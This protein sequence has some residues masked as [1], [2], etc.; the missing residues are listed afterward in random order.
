MSNP[1]SDTAQF[2]QTRR[3]E[4]DPVANYRFSDGDS[5]VI[6]SAVF[7]G[8]G[9]SLDDASRRRHGLPFSTWDRVLARLRGDD[10]D[11]D[12]G[13]EDRLLHADRAYY[14][15]NGI[16]EGDTRDLLRAWK[17]RIDPRRHFHPFDTASPSSSDSVG[18]VDLPR[19]RRG[20]VPTD[21]YARAA[22]AAQQEDDAL[23]PLDPL[24]RMHA[25][26]R[27]QRQLPTTRRDDQEADETNYFMHPFASDDED[28]RENEHEIEEN[29]QLGEHHASSSAPPLLAAPPIPAPPTP[30]VLKPEGRRQAR[31][32][33]LP[34]ATNAPFPTSESQW[35]LP[36]PDS[37]TNDTATASPTLVKTPWERTMDRIKMISSIQ[38]AR[39]S[40]Q[41]DTTTTT[42]ANAA[43]KLLVPYFPPAFDP[44]FIALSR[45]EHG[46]RLPPILLPLLNASV[47]DSEF[48]EGQNQW[49]F[50]IELQYGDIKWV[51]YRTIADFV[52]L[53]YTL[54]F[55]S[56]LLA[57]VPA[58]PPFPNQLQ[59]LYDSCITT[60][61]W[62][63]KDDDVDADSQDTLAVDENAAAARIDASPDGQTDPDEK[64][65]ALERRTA[66]TRYLQQLFQRAHRHISYDVC[67]FLEMS[68]ISMVQDMGWK[69]KEGYLRQRNHLVQHRCC[70]WLTS[71]MWKTQWVLLRDSYIA[72]C[73]DIAASSPT[74]VL[75]LDNSFTM[76]ATKPNLLG[77]YHLILTNQTRRIQ[78]KGNKRELDEWSAQ[79]KKVQDGS[80][81]IRQHRFDSFAPVRRHAKV[82]WFVDAENHFN[83]VA[84]AILSAKVEIYIADWWL[85]PELYLRRPP[86]ENE[87]FRLDRLLQRKAREGVMIYIVIYKEMSLALTIDSEHTKLWLQSL[88]PNIMVQRHPDHASIDNN[89]VLFWS[90]H[91]KMVVVDNRLAFI[92]GLDLCFGRYDS[93]QHSLSDFHPEHRDR[94]NFPGQDYSNPRNKDFV[95]VAQY[96]RTLV[97]RST[98]PRMPWHDVTL[99]TVG[100]VARDIAR[101][102]IQRWNYIKTTKAMHRHNLPF[103][104][105]KGEYVAA[106]DE[107][108]FKGSCRVQVLRS[109]SA[110]SSGVQREH[111]IYN[112]YIECISQA[113]HFIYIENQ[114]FISATDDDKILRNKIAQALVQ[115]II[116]AHE[117]REKFKVFVVLPLVPAFEGDLASSESSSARSVMHFQYATMCR[118]DASIVSRLRRAGINPSDYIDWYS[119]RNWGSIRTPD[120]SHDD[121]EQYVTEILYIHD[122]LMIVDDRIALIGS[123]NINDRSQL[124][125]R[126]SEIAMLIEDTDTIDAYMDGKPYKASRFAHT[127]RL[128][129]WK[130]HLGLLDMDSNWSSLLDQTDDSTVASDPIDLV[131]DKLQVLATAAATVRSHGDADDGQDTHDDVEMVDSPAPAGS[132]TGHPEM[133]GSKKALH[134]RLATYPPRT[135]DNEQ[136][137]QRCEQE[138]PVR[139]IDR[140]SRSRSMYDTTRQG[141]TDYTDQ[142]ACARVLDPLADACY[143][144]LW[145]KTATDNTDIYRQLF[146]CVPDDTIHTFDQHRDFVNNNP[147]RY[148]HIVNPLL[149]GHEVLSQLQQI[150]G[151]LVQFP[152]DYLK[153]ETL[154]GGNLIESMTPT[155]IFT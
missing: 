14:P 15:G 24:D 94:V 33:V 89:N 112:A 136:E 71:R 137:I 96:D 119:L 123:A 57:N 87:D 107:H 127:L 74:A 154:N 73:D 70:Q 150:R 46:N 44:I 147:D 48:L 103:L 20:S 84:E 59:A 63:R 31:Y 151:H 132:N 36:E 26:E 138:E 77:N 29:D 155:I 86:H 85:T 42:N 141:K 6:R 142:H 143:H 97:D 118:G 83:A 117:E 80:P 38:P 55:K 145:R 18:G 16:E 68:A 67:E 134:A 130:E 109:S 35:T 8:R 104:M 114:F 13:G 54:K 152:L 22:A 49:A 99:A 47:T 4:D 7:S 128:Q 61:G 120:M 75:M 115:R 37:P 135:H 148:G 88:H 93:H 11:E 139:M 90:H 101:H 19:R 34:I 153:N 60:I 45:D 81:W 3:Q 56:S 129:L 125:N 140:M 79:I 95:D 41:I 116:R 1:I 53:H 105:P 2:F 76:H 62:D 102:F 30:V 50:R 17:H 72:F 106:R 52:M 21:A 10:D 66:L 92:G 78:L 64:R 111:S 91:E 121:P 43:A 124:G 58:P 40:L 69:G 113:Q 28:E 98:C 9:G 5:R 146:H 126:D 39:L 12:D 82:K 108:K 25:P 100:P 149:A 122:K 133:E 110:W 65:D 27:P 144:S 23:P 131:I 32:Q 51:L